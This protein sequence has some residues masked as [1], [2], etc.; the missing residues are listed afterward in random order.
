MCLAAHA[1]EDLRILVSLAGQPE[2]LTSI[3]DLAGR[4]G[5]SRNHLMKDAEPRGL[6]L[7]LRTAPRPSPGGNPGGG[8]G[9]RARARPRARRLLHGCAS[10]PLTGPLGRARI[11]VLHERNA[12]SLADRV[13]PEGVPRQR[14]SLPPAIDG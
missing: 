5:L 1:D 14:I 4:P 11:A 7:R 12:V 9:L 10:C 3:E 6:R 8:G 13:Q 2:R